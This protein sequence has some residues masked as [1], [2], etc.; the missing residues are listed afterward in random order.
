MVEAITSFQE[1]SHHPNDLSLAPGV[2]SGSEVLY[3]A[4]EAAQRRNAMKVST[5]IKAGRL[6]LNVNEGLIRDK[7]RPKRRK[8]RGKEKRQ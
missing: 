7:G 2:R 8:A 5:Q 1:L 6:S 4:A 3:R